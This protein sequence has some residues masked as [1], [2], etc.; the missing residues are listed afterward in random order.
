M[1]LNIFNSENIFKEIKLKHET[2]NKLIKFLI[3]EI[4]TPKLYRNY[5]II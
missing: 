5:C 1:V 4:I 2:N 3:L